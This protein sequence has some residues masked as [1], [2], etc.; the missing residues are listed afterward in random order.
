VPKA[1]KKLF[2][3]IPLQIT[4]FFY[5]NKNNYFFMTQHTATKTH[6]TVRS[7]FAFEEHW[8]AYPKYAGFRPS[9]SGMNWQSVKD[10]FHRSYSYDTPLSMM[11]SNN[12]EIISVTVYGFKILAEPLAL[13]YGPNPFP[14]K[15]VLCRR[16]A[17]QERIVIYF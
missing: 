16:I 13:N 7:L 3:A 5:P 4:R 17:T 6:E 11:V 2:L 8:L 15:A 12:K 10:H 14:R 9:F 1:T